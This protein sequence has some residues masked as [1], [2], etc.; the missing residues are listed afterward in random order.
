MKDGISPRVEEGA[1]L[2]DEGECIKEFLPERMH[3]EHLMGCIPVKEK[4]L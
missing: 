4:G 1:A 3:F 2:G